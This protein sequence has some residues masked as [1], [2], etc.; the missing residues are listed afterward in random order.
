MAV[1]GQC[2]G[3]RSPASQ[4]AD[5]DDDNDDDGDHGDSDDD[6]VDDQC[7]RTKCLIDCLQYSLLLLAGKSRENMI[8]FERK[9][10]YW[11]PH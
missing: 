6:D 2:Q 10:N 9:F 11:S 3:R 4:D 7:Q 1:A 5:N 8:F